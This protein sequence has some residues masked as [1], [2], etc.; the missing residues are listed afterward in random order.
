MSGRLGAT[1][2][3]NDCLV[4]GASST[5]GGDA[6]KDGGVQFDETVLFD[7]PE[8]QWVAQQTFRLLKLSC[9]P[10]A[11]LM[12][13][14]DLATVHK[15]MLT[16][17]NRYG[18]QAVLGDPHPYRL[19]HGGPSRTSCRASALTQQREAVRKGRPRGSAAEKSVQSHVVAR[20]GSRTLNSI[21]GVQPALSVGKFPKMRV[22]IEIFAG[23]GALGKSL[24]RVCGGLVLLWDI[25]LGPEYDLRNPHKPSLILQWIRAGVIESSLVC[26]WALRARASPGLGTFLLV[27][28][29]CEAMT[30]HWATGVTRPSTWRPAGG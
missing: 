29:L 20:A 2:G 1:G 23:T 27:L 5:R 30:C 13:S 7:L 8:I 18:I 24:Y 12:F 25:L 14:V 21:G 3:S 19:R 22:Y 11:E 10:Q 9:R 4:L 28:L 26:T 15:F 16:V 17:F 6:L